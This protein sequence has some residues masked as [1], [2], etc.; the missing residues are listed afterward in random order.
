MDRDGAP[1]AD[2]ANAGRANAAGEVV[3]YV[4]DEEKTAVSEVRPAVSV[5]NLTLKRACRV[6]DLTKGL[7]ELNPFERE[8]ERESIGWHHEIRG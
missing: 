8:I 5:T 4:A 3:L 2:K 7:P 1:P 6:L